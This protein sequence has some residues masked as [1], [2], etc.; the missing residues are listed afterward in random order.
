MDVIE[1]HSFDK[2]PEKLPRLAFLNLVQCNK[3]RK[4]AGTMFY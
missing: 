2:L 3:V 4:Q 1:G